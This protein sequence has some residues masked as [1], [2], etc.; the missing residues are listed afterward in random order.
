M[1]YEYSIDDPF[2][3]DWDWVANNL[4]DLSLGRDTFI[5]NV[6][7]NYLMLHQRHAYQMILRSKQGRDPMYTCVKAM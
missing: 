3:I 5:L 7:M 2:A 4:H 1:D 6:T